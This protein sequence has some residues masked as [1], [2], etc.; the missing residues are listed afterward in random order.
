L[1]NCKI[2]SVF[3]HFPPEYAAKIFSICIEKKRAIFI[4]E[5]I[6]RNLYSCYKLFFFVFIAI[7]IPS[8][9]GKKKRGMTKESF[10]TPACASM[11]PW[12]T[13]HLIVLKKSF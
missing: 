6:I 5:P 8:L 7:Q 10:G 11:L 1:N 12:I 2:I 13:G 9:K 4:L 3:H